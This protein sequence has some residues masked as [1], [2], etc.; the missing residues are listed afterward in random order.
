MKN[1]KGMRG[2]SSKFR[3]SRRVYLFLYK[4]VNSRARLLK[5]KGVIP[6]DKIT[7]HETCF[8]FF[9]N[10]LTNKKE[11]CSND[12]HGKDEENSST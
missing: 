3:L 12:R 10:C 8:S 4:Q 9:L 6:C 11:L 5:K 7:R 2:L 1:I